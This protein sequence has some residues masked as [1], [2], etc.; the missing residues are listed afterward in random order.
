M[1]LAMRASR[2]LLQRDFQIVGAG[3][4]CSCREVRLVVGVR[5]QRDA[6]GRCTWHFDNRRGGGF[7]SIGTGA[8]MADAARVEHAQCVAQALHFIVEDVIVGERA[9]IDVRDLQHAHGLGVGAE[10]E[11]LLGARPLLEM[12]GEGAFQIDDAQI[13]LCQMR[14]HVAPYFFRL[15]VL[16]PVVDQAAEHY[17]S[18]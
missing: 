18:G 5:E 8:G 3:M 11:H 4:F 9:G 2:F 14:Q 17:V 15:H 1:S 6:A 10:M 12:G 7:F 16:E 13:G